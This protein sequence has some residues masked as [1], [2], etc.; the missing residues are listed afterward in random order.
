MNL[1]DLRYLVAVADLRHFGRAAEACFVSQP[2]LSTQLKKLE[3]HLGVQL[4]ER[5]H[6]HVLITPVGEAIAARARRILQE[7]DELVETARMHRDPL[8]GD[9]RVGVIPT[10]GPYLLPHLIPAA[11][12]ALPR[13]RLLLYEEKTHHILAQLRQGILE[14][15]ILAVPVEDDGLDSELLFREPFLL[16]APAA[17]APARGRRARTEQLRDTPV[18]LLEEGHCLR[19][20][21]LDV[22]HTVGAT[23]AR[24]FRAT[25][26]ETLRQMVASGAGVTLLPELAARVNNE[27]PNGA[28]IRLCRFE[29]PQPYRDIALLWRS[30]SAREPAL[31]A[32]ARC[33]QALDVLGRMAAP[34][35]R[36]SSKGRR[37]ASARR[38]SP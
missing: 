7:T 33:V 37:T 34:A 36:A 3:Q 8:A 30:G 17:H 28:D 25:S 19:D 4:V 22:C 1:R 14:A 26:L 38:A 20:Q 23:E 6:R 16:A 2:T 35:R 24:E 27:I 32:L 15:V 18:L 5:S 13:L 31:K 29:D 12:T 9:L 21:A 11:R 10:L